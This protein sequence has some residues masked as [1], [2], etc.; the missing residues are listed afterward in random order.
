A[1]IEHIRLEDINALELVSLGREILGEPDLKGGKAILNK[2][3]DV[4]TALASRLLSAIRMAIAR[5]VDK[6]EANQFA[7]RAEFGFYSPAASDEEIAASFYAALTELL[8]AFDRYDSDEAPS[9]AV[10]CERLA[11]RMDP[12]ERTHM[13]VFYENGD[14]P[15]SL[16]TEAESSSDEKTRNELYELAADLANGQE[17]FSRVLK[18]VQRI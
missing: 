8:P 14:T 16:M 3:K 12:V 13:Y 6:L 5:S 7:S 4:D 1:A 10:L 18:I 2:E 9:A 15:E 17:S 11:A